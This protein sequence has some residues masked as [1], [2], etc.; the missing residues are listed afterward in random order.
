MP[1]RTDCKCAQIHPYHANGTHTCRS[2]SVDQTRQAALHAPGSA[3][4]G[5]L[6]WSAPLCRLPI[7]VHVCIEVG[8]GK[9]LHILHDRRLLEVAL[10]GKTSSA[11]CL[12]VS[13]SLKEFRAAARFRQALSQ[14][15]IGNG[16]RIRSPGVPLSATGSR[17]LPAQ[18]FPASFFAVFPVCSGASVA[19]S[20]CGSRSGKCGARSQN[21]NGLV[22][23]A[24]VVILDNKLF[25]FGG[26]LPMDTF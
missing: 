21:T 9:R 12:S 16:V 4:R 22:R 20:R 8:R 10:Y 3:P 15:L 25:G 23:S 14:L 1:C 17:C 11:A 26:Q 6:R 2:R 24:G 7:L 13:R 19:A 18:A 5:Q